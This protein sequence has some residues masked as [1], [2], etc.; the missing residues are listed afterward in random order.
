MLCSI[1]KHW[2]RVNKFRR[3][4]LCKRKSKYEAA[5]HRS[6]SASTPHA[7][8]QTRL[9]LQTS[10]SSDCT[11]FFTPGTEKYPQ[12]YSGFGC[13][14][15]S[16]NIPVKFKLLVRL[17]YAN[18]RIFYLILLPIWIYGELQTSKTQTGMEM[19]GHSF[20]FPS[21]LLFRSVCPSLPNKDAISKKIASHF[22][23]KPPPPPNF[24]SA[25]RDKHSNKKAA[26]WPKNR[27]MTD[28]F[29]RVRMED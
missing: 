15:I 21:T 26:T 19:E 24:S 2:E 14:L 28:K 4:R 18:P 16:Y 10:Q 8:D 6:R 11:S 17:G 29:Q 22:I 27:R 13:L 7:C 25:N 5:E 1:S 12:I 20:S 23:D 3:A 9:P